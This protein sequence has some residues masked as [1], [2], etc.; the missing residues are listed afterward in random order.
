MTISCPGGLYGVDVGALGHTESSLRTGR[1]PAILLNVRAP[2]GQGVIEIAGVSG[3][4]LRQVRHTLLRLR[5]CGRL[6]RYQMTG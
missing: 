3:L 2:S 6:N 1:V 4:T 5:C